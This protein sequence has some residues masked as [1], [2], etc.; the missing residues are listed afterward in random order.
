MKR[1][2]SICALLAFC[3]AGTALG[4]DDDKGKG[5]GKRA[6]GEPDAMFK[7]L[8]ANNDGKVSKEEFGKLR[9]N[10]PGK[11]KE[12]ANGK[13]TGQLSD[14]MFD[15]MDG[16]KDGSLS[17]EEFKK[18]RERMTERLKKVKGKTDK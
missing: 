18:V 15:L 17:L 5:K 3:F 14:R 16:N 1:Y 4:S 10:L 11:I 9:D 13:G 8:D 6:I 2:L 12:K 7:K